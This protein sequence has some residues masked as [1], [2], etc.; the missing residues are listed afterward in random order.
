M[1]SNLRGI[2]FPDCADKPTRKNKVVM[3]FLAFLAALVSQAVIGFV[4]TV[5]VALVAYNVA[6]RDLVPSLP[7]VSVYNGFLLALGLRAVRFLL[8]R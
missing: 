3:A 7:A 8:I 5:L 4:V 1:P 6:L 2:R